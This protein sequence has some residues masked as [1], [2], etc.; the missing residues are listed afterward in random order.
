MKNNDEIARANRKILR[1]AISAQLTTAEA[2][3]IELA[4]SY[5]GEDEK[6]SACHPR[7][8]FLS[9]LRQIERI[10]KGITKASV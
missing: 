1:D 6:F 2:M 4:A 10:N 8:A 9:V 7:M 3:L 5:N